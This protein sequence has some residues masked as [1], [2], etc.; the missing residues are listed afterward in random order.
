M[1]YV[2][3]FFLWFILLWVGMSAVVAWRAVGGDAEAIIL[4]ACKGTAVY[5]L[6]A[7]A[8]MAFCFP[9][10]WTMVAY[11]L[12]APLVNL[13]RPLAPARSGRG[14][15]DM[16]GGASGEIGEKNLL[17]TIEPG[18]AFLVKDEK[19]VALREVDGMKHSFIF[20][21]SWCHLIMS[22]CCKLTSL[23]SY[24]ANAG[25]ARELRIS[26]DDP[27]EYFCTMDIPPGEQIVIHPSDLIGCSEDIS[28][29]TRWS[30]SPQ[31]FY[32]GQMRFYVMQGPERELGQQP[33]RVVVRSL[34][35]ITSMQIKDSGYALKKHCLI[36]ATS[37][38]RMGV[39]RTESFWNY[40]NGQA[41]LFDLYLSGTGEVR[42][43]N[44]RLKS[45]DGDERSNRTFREALCNFLGF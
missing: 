45:T 4:D 15:G 20:V 25:K 32:A 9:T 26:S 35:G 36:A 23:V 29:R 38:V 34:G 41:D 33:A 3:R 42:I 40:F 7:A 31:A 21:Y 8:F 5:A 30:F 12:L 14:Q 37:G 1:K 44:A 27:D 39:K 10:I 2:K 17:I 16:M 6:A 28:L 11:Y 22:I 24:K 19:Y 43:H 18:E 13:W